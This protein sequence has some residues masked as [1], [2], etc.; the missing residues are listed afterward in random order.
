MNEKLVGW[1]NLNDY[2]SRTSLYRYT[3]EMELFVHPGHKSKGIGKCLIDKLLEMVDPGYHVRG[4]YE[5]V[6]DYEYLKTGPARVIKTILVN[7][8]HENGEDVDNEWQGKFLKFCKFY[9]A[10]RLSSMGYK[11]GKVVD[12]TI[13][14]HHT[15]EDIN[16]D[17]PPAVMA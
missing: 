7:C 12:V 5:Y 3:F 13:Y 14:T 1:I 10:G 17:V 4:G 6:N 8:H 9:R 11:D 15:R 16:A 2:C